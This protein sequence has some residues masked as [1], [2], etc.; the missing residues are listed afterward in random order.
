LSRAEEIKASKCFIAFLSL[1]DLKE[2]TTA[3]KQFEKIKYAKDVPKLV[4]AK[5]QANVQMN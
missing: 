1:S 2:Y 3:V 4:T 5:G